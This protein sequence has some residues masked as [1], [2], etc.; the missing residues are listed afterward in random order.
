MQSLT[1]R[2]QNSRTLVLSTDERVRMLQRKLYLKAKQD[3]KFK[4]YVLYDKIRID[5]FLQE[6]YRRVKANAETPAG[7]NQS[8]YPTNV[9]SMGYY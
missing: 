9:H 1:T 5:Y 8:Y 6:A 7:Q 2:L 4:F 3:K